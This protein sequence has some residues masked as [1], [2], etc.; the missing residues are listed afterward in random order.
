MLPLV[1]AGVLVTS[2]AGHELWREQWRDDGVVITSEVDAGPEHFSVTVDRKRRTVQLRHGTTTVEKS[3]AADAVPIVNGAFASYALVAE[4][5]KDGQPPAP[6]KLFLAERDLTF[7][8]TAQLT[9]SANGGRR[10]TIKSSVIELHVDFDGHGAVVHADLPAQKIEV[11][12]GSAARAAPAVKPAA[13]PPAVTEEP[14]ALDNGGAHLRGVTWRPAAQAR[15]LPLVIL[16]AGSGPTDRDGNSAVGL[17]TD[18]YRLLAAALADHGVASLRYDKRGVGE[19]TAP[20]RPVTFEDFVSDAAALVTQAR[21]S[22]RYSAVYLLGHSE[23][24]LIALSVGA[25]LPDVDGIIS[26]AGPGRPLAAIL[27]EQL[28]RQLPANELA[29]LDHAVAELRAGRAVAP[30]QS[31]T[32][33]LLFRPTLESFLRQALFADPLALA[34]AQKTPLTIVQGDMDAQVSVEADARALA[35]ARPDAK[36]VVLHEVAHT[37]KLEKVKS[38]A[39]R[40]YQDPSLP[41]A[42]GVVDAV[43]SALRK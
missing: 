41:L 4:R 36:L 6:F 37:L 24:A 42:P 5:F 2:Q 27:R 26:V 25:R 38:V 33:R 32:L 22:R 35:Q 15:P 1:L 9:K 7:D 23:G 21:A 43:L 34:R 20:A 14:L 16:V 17:H 31:S 19:S 28:A 12:P 30:L 29:E 39:Q 3:L 8:A 18:T 13:P 11:V 10:L 40:S